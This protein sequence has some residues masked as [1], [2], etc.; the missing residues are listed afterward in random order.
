MYRMYRWLLILGVSFCFPLW[1]MGQAFIDHSP[2]KVKKKLE[3]YLEEN[4]LRSAIVQ[5]DSVISLLIDDPRA[6]PA[7]FIFKFRDEKCVEEVKI[8]CDTCV[9]KYLD[10]ILQNRSMEWKKMNES[11]WLSKF[12]KHRIMIVDLNGHSSSLIIRKT[13]WDKKTYNG[14]IASLE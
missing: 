13:N 3:K 10:G 7:S 14:V 5:K 6:K 12:S 2:S 8:A 9:M 11:T 4:D 1:V